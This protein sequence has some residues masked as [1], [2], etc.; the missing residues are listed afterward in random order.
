MSEHDDKAAVAIVNQALAER[1]FGGADPIGRH[2]REGDD[3]S[4]KSVYEVIGVVA[5]RQG[6]DR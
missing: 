2:V 6:G 3:P 5:E 4:G 1:L